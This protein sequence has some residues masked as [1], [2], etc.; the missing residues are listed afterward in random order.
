MLY[1]GRSRPARLQDR[2]SGPYRVV[3]SLG[4]NKYTIAIP[5][6]ASAG[7]TRDVDVTLMKLYTPYTDG[8]PSNWCP[9]PITEHESNQ[10]KQFTT[11]KSV[12]PGCMVV[13][14]IAATETKP[15]TF[16]IA[17]VMSVKGQELKLQWF[18]NY[19]NNPLGT[20]RKG[21][22]DIVK[23]KHYYRSKR[24]R[25]SHVEY[26]S[27]TSRTKVTIDQVPISGFTLSADDTIPSVVRD[28]IHE[29]GHYEWTLPMKL[30]KD[31]PIIT[32]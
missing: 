10:R 13:V 31:Q 28:M 19:S 16:A 22:V 11:K 21:W 23:N 8:E 1:T 3:R 12:K 4:S 27:E 6:T 14:P 7:K 20:H 15:P 2:W 29:S 25:K 18:G 30:R 26:T 24:E 17:Q 32:V 9:E 5:S